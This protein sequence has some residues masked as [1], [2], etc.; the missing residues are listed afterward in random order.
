ME[1][2]RTADTHFADLR[3]Y[4]FAPNYLELSGL[5]MHYVDAGP[6]SARPVLMLH[7]EPT[8]SYLYRH[9]IP[10][11]ARAGHRVLAPDLIGFGKSD[12]PVHGN[13]YTY[14]RHV[15]WIKGFI[16]S[17]D[18]R[19]ITLFCQD[20]GALIGLRVAVEEDERFDR[21]VIGNGAL[22]A[23][24]RAS[25]PRLSGA[26][27]FFAWQLFARYSPKFPVSAIVNTGCHRKLSPEERRA[28]DAPFPAPEALAGA[29]A[30]PKLV[31]IF[32]HDPA[33]EPNRAAWQALRRWRKPF[34]TLFSD[35]DPITRGGERAFQSQ[36]PGACEQPHATLHAGHFLQEDVGPELARRINDFISAT[37][38]ATWE[39]STAST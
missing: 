25:A 6:R 20:W 31:P 17:L 8:W 5:R 23:A 30:F 28:Y 21:I 35:G 12:K 14:Q 24:Q 7:G 39:A 11:C 32:S 9:M 22:P 15:D 38:D 29:R 33:V 10:V 26:L 4:P 34:L 27:A 3:D 2:Y 36:V 16:R 1:F 19:G 13:N 18:L 37:A